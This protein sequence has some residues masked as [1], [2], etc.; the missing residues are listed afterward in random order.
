MH[1][2]RQW[3][4]TPVLLPRES[5]GQGRLVCYSPWG[6]KVS[7]TTAQLSMHILDK[8]HILRFII[9]ELILKVK[10][11]VEVQYV[12]QVKAGLFWVR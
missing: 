12:K 10:F 7:D 2:R 9:I 8:C 5:H 6:C 11:D 4:L 1:W 3:Q